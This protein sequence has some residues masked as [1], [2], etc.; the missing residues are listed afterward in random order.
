MGSDSRKPNL[1]SRR[2]EGAEKE[3]PPYLDEYD[4]LRK[5]PH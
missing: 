5:S 1:I 3:L 2:H 4:A